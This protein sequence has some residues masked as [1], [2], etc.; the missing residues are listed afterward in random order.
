MIRQPSLFDRLNRPGESIQ[1]RF[2]AFHTAHPEVFQE[3]VI[4]ARQWK[5]AGRNKAG[6]EMFFAV[7]RWQRG[8]RGLPDANEEFKLNDHYT[9]R[10]ARLIMASCPDLDGMFELRGLR[11]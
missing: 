11:S 3:L 10:Y 7:L 6:I 5:R 2:E 9:S 4:L 1:E 8:I